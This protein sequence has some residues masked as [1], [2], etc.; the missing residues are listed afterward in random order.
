MKNIKFYSSINV[1]GEQVIAD[2][3]SGEEYVQCIKRS[4]I[5]EVVHRS[6]VHVNF[7]FLHFS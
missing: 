3:L 4:D 5:S 7:F 6:I 2:K 1:H